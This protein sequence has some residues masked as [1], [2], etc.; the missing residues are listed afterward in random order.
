MRPHRQR[1][2]ITNLPVDQFTKSQENCFLILS[3]RSEFKIGKFFTIILCVIGIIFHTDTLKGFSMQVM[4]PLLSCLVLSVVALNGCL[5]VPG[6]TDFLLVNLYTQSS[7]LTTETFFLFPYYSG[8]T[9]DIIF[10]Y[11]IHRFIVCCLGKGL[12]YI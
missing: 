2:L 3:S 8:C 12:Q 7:F 1:Q 9:F 4:V 11:F 5:W 10:V 6:C